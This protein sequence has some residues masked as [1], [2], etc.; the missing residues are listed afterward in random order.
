MAQKEIEETIIEKLKKVV[1]NKKIIAEETD[2]MITYSMGDVYTT[3]TVDVERKVKKLIEVEDEPEEIIDIVLEEIEDETEDIQDTFNEEDTTDE[4]TEDE[5]QEETLDEIQEDEPDEVTDEATDEVTDEATDDSIKEEILEETKDEET[6]EKEP[7]V[8]EVIQDDES[9]K[10]PEEVQESE[11]EKARRI[12]EKSEPFEPHIGET[13]V[14]A[15]S[16]DDFNESFKKELTISNVFIKEAYSQIRNMLDDYHFTR[17]MSD[18][19]EEFYHDDELLIRISLFDRALRMYVNLDENENT[20]RYSLIDYKG[21]YGY[22]RVN[23]MHKVNTPYS[24]KLALELIKKII[25]KYEIEH[26]V[27][28]KYFDFVGLLTVK[29]ADLLTEAGFDG[30]VDRA[31]Y[32]AAEEMSDELMNTGTVLERSLKEPDPRFVASISVGELSAAFKQKYVI[33]L[34][35]LKDVGLAS[36]RSTYLK[37]TSGGRCTRKIT[38]KADEYED[39][40]LKMILLAKGNAIK[41]I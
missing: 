17:T 38:V 11:E 41:M 19:Y 15:E 40:A 21:N 13:H 39:A 1:K 3:E 14:T 20:Y 16:I 36:K 6:E 7:E 4:V 34:K 12:R 27:D 37:V 2:D 24:L 26:T 8:E 35:L 25:K 5:T 22:N 31:N 9:E 18:H 32:E 23:Y 28:Y 33:D 30:F 10:E 29:S